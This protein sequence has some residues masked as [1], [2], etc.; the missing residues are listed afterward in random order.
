MS[1]YDEDQDDD[2]DDDDDDLKQIV[3]RAIWKPGQHL[4]LKGVRSIQQKQLVL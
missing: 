2:D 4:V 3:R 1:S